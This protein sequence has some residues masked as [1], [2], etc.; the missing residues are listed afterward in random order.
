MRLQAPQ[1][2]RS[3]VLIVR[4]GSSASRLGAT[5][6]PARRAGGLDA[7]CA[8]VG[9]ATTAN[10]KRMRQRERIVR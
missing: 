3:P 1:E 9:Q 5:R 8:R 10:G 2:T 7:A 6:R 4:T